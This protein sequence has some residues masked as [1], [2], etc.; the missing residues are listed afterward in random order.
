MYVAT[1]LFFNIPGASHLGTNS[2]PNTV[3]PLTEVKSN[4]GHLEV[5]HSCDDVI[6]V[7]W[8]NDNNFENMFS[9]C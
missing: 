3:V 8:N 4:L 2:F 7:D 9:I 6:A 5:G 1:I